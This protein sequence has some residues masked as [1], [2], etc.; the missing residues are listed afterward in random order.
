MIY[1][2][3]TFPK[4]IQVKALGVTKEKRNIIAVFMGKD[5][6]K[7]NIIF[8][9]CGVHGREWITIMLALYIIRTIGE[10]NKYPELLLPR[11][12]IIPVANPDGYVYSY[13]TV[14]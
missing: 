1:L 2:K 9:T 14:K 13:Q 3:K 12:I 11:W 4:T 5:I 10:L 6:P 7:N 8:I